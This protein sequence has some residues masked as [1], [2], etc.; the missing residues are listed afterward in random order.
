MAWY[1]MRKIRKRYRNQDENEK[2]MKPYQK[3]EKS[4]D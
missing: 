3:K 1:I 2:E 4:I